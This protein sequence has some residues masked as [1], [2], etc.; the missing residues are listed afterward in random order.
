MN[1]GR[2]R[3]VFELLAAAAVAAA[4]IIHLIVVPEHW[5][6]APAHALFF[7]AVGLI[8]LAWAVVV[9]WRPTFEL[10]Q[11]GALLAGSLIVLWIITRVLPAPFG[12]G[13]EEIDAGGLVCKLS[14]LIGLVSAAIV[15]FR[16]ALADRGSLAARRS[17]GVLLVV[18]VLLGSGGYL[19]GRVIEPLAP[20]LGA[21]H[22]HTAP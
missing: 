12:H 10:M 21:T 5:E 9:V 8:E 18:M 22:E 20:Q 13:P 3:T 17:L 16:H 19:V 11:I 15:L 2:S 1:L 6:H 4:G 14:E 7:I